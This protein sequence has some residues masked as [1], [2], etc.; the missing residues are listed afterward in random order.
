MQSFKRLLPSLNALVT[1]EAAA[2]LRSFTAA[3]REL[4]V[5]Q[6]AVSRQIRLVEDDLAT[7]LFE[8][9]HR[10][11][12]LTPAGAVLAATLSQSLEQ[13]NDAV[14][15]IRAPQAGATLTVA[16]TLAF[17]H[18]WLMPRLSEFR[19]RHPDTNIRVVSEDA[20]MDLRSGGI[21]VAIRYGV[22]PFADAE[23]VA[24]RPDIVFPV[25]SPEFRDRVGAEIS[26]EELSRLPLIASDQPDPTWLGWRQWFLAAGFGKISRVS[27][28]QFNHYTDSISAAMIGEGV[29]LGWGILMERILAQGQLVR[30]TDAVVPSP[31]PYHVVTPLRRKPN[32]A[33]DAFLAWIAEA[34]AAPHPT[35]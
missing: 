24:S 6:A 9:R 10:R 30:L 26:L 4:G 29:A 2:R 32:P 17:S 3:A 8:R 15:L 5:T 12:E 14:E 16:A 18:F 28:P 33:A 25:C 34:F 11:V 21:D 7:L 22:P 27:P 31:A 1:F 20:P 13:I 35:T 23:I 19:V